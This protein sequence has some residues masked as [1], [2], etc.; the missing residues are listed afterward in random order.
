M[1]IFLIVTCL[2]FT[3]LCVVILFRDGWIWEAVLG[4]GLFGGGS[5]LLIYE[6]ELDAWTANRRLSFQCVIR[7]DHL[8][9]PKGY[10]F[11]HGCL[12]DQNTLPFE[13]IDEIRIN[14]FP[15]T[16]VVKGQEIIFLRGL[17]KEDLAPIQG[18]PFTEPLDHW[19]LICDE[20][21]DTEFDEE[22]K[23]RAL[24]QLEQAGIPETEVL[25][26]RKRLRL[27]MLMRT[28]ATWEWIYYGQWD[29]MSELWPMTAKKYWWTMD[30]A[31]RQ[32]PAVPLT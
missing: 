5:L 10:Y 21:L 1:R 7:D 15:P 26:I 14:T 8:L 12:K 31:L 3:I 16:A 4:I 25:A 6:K 18:I 20:F 22:Y 28:Y 11:K 32:P 13:W 30:V 23:A 27:R 9:F 29:V 19:T 17:T 24:T 2:L